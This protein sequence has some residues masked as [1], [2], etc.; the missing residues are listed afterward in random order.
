LTSES[1]GQATF[2]VAL[3]TQPT[4][5]VI[6]AV[7]SSD[8]SEGIV[9]PA[10]LTFTADDWQTPQVITGMDDQLADGPVDYT[11]TGTATEYVGFDAPDV[12]VT[13]LD[14]DPYV[15]CS[16]PNMLDDMEDLDANICAIGGPRR[17]LVLRRRRLRQLRSQRAL[18]HQRRAGG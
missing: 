18:R 13:N 4:A 1:G 3:T 11:A 9:A 6:V 14:N 10:S 2:T 12:M 5:S 16:D 15:A 8:A 7:S 17:Q